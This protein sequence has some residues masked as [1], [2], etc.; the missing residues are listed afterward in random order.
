MPLQPWNEM[1]STPSSF[2]H[3][4]PWHV[5]GYVPLLGLNAPLANSAA[6]APQAVT[7]GSVLGTHAAV[8]LQVQRLPARLPQSQLLGRFPCSLFFPRRTLPLERD[9]LS[10]SRVR[11]CPPG[12][13]GGIKSLIQSRLSVGQIGWVDLVRFHTPSVPSLFPDCHPFSNRL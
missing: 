5:N 1:L 3:S 7:F 4:M 12:F 8:Y 13:A 11:G 2:L 6:N 10:I 9:P